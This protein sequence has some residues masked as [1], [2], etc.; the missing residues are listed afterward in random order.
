[1]CQ[2]DTHLT[3]G[4]TEAEEGNSP[5]VAQAGRSSTRI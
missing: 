3:E 1:M 5:K 2:E 4:E